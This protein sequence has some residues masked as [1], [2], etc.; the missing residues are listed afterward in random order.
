MGKLNKFRYYYKD[1]Y[2]WLRFQYWR[3]RA[4]ISDHF[5]N[6]EEPITEKEYWRERER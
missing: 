3:I 5:T 4:Y 6:G 1:F 2:E